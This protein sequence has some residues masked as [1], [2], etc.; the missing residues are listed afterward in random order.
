M[1]NIALIGATGFVGSAIL[2]ELINNDFTVTAIARDVTTLKALPHVVAVQADV[3]EETALLA[4]LKGNDAVISAFNAGWDNPN[5]YAD[6]LAG[7]RSI[8]QA[9]KESGIKRAIFVG[10]AGSL[11]VD[12]QKLVDA[13]DFPRAIKDGARAASD[14]LEIIKREP[15]LDW[16]FVSP[17][18][19]MKKESSGKRTGKFRTGFDN[20]VFDETGH[21]VISV[22]DLA[23]AIV[24]ELKDGQFIKVR[25]TVGY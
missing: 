5:I 3:G 2:N 25:F 15:E 18:I 16:T 14:Y 24:H 6:Y 10:G 8:V 22:E 12:G 11:E 7:G 20:P 4:A 1:K 17:A 9:I 21:S 13:P 23:M 19:E